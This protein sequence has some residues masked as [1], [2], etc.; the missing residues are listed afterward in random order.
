MVKIVPLDNIIHALPYHLIRLDGPE[1][2]VKGA[3]RYKVSEIDV[4]T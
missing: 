4:F 1:R 2:V 3:L